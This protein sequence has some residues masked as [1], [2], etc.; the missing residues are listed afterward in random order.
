M[1]EVEVELRKLLK[2]IF[3]KLDA[4]GVGFIS[5]DDLSAAVSGLGIEM[6]SWRGNGG[7]FFGRTCTL[8][9]IMLWDPFAAKALGKPNPSFTGIYVYGEVHI[10]V[11]E[12]LLGIPSTCFFEVGAD[13]G[14][15]FFVFAEGPTYGARMALGVDGRV[16]CLLGI[17]G[18][19]DLLG[20][21]VNGKTQVTGKGEFC[22]TL[23]WIDVCKD[24]TIST[25]VS[26]DGS[27]TGSS[28]TK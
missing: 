2:P 18:R 13:A 20:G 9:P 17:S 16:A 8:D 24:V 28:D 21:K 1:D 7:V 10:P 14:V 6:Q 25:A 22:A 12:V 27:L 4:D 19:I 5:S 3:S 26:S 15:G 11:S 23:F